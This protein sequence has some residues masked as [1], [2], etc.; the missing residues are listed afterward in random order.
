MLVTLG[1]GAMISDLN[2]LCFHEYNWCFG[3]YLLIVCTCCQPE[4]ETPGD[5]NGDIDGNGWQLEGYM[6]SFCVN[7]LIRCSIKWNTLIANCSLIG[8]ANRMAGQKM[9]CK[10]LLQARTA[11]LGIHAYDCLILGCYIY[12]SCFMPSYLYFMSYLIHATP[13]YLSLCIRCF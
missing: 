7:A 4:P 6:Y 2:T 1:P 11:K 8:P 3:S 10:F 13:I 9:P 12:L 5:R